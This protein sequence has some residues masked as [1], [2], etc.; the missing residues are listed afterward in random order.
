MNSVAWSVGKASPSMSKVASTPE[1]AEVPATPVNWRPSDERKPSGQTV[2]IGLLTGCRDKP[3]VYGL[4]MAL[5]SAGIAI[6]LIGND[7]VDSPDFRALPNF[8][9][10]NWGGRPQPSDGLAIKLLRAATYYARLISYAFSDDRKIYHILWNYKFEY[11]DRI[12]LTLYYKLLGKRIALTAHNVNTAKRDSQDSWLNRRTLK[13]QYRIADHIFVH[14]EKMKSE[15]VDEFEV[16][17]EK[18]TVIPFGINNVAPDTGLNVADARRCLG[19]GDGERTILF[20]GN[21]GPYKGVEYLVEAFKK[22]RGPRGTYR[23]IIAGKHRTDSEAY[24]QSIRNAARE[25]VERGEITL[26]IEHIP[27]AETE[28]YFKAADILVLPYTFVSQSGVLFLGYSFGLPVIA[29]DVGALGEEIV[30]GETGFLCKPRDSSDL[31]STIERYFD[32]NLYRSLNER[33]SVIRDFANSRHSWSVV[34]EK[35]LD[36][37]R[38]LTKARS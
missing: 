1:S 32:S 17:K 37:Y 27:D 23:L 2:A 38:D 13:C 29:T 16:R 25:G 21:I 35:T 10:L 34:A 28:I 33:R 26:R 4:A 8:N 9:F 24:V 36:V 30:E 31:A 14:T 15:L 19:I 3:Y 7:D 12:G 18:V 6:D 22:L 11:L 5:S 20:F